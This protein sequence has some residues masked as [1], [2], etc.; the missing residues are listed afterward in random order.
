MRKQKRVLSEEQLCVARLEYETAFL[1]TAKPW[2][3]RLVLILIK[4]FVYVPTV[5][6]DDGERESLRAVVLPTII[7]Y[8]MIPCF[9]FSLL[10]LS[11]LLP[12]NFIL[13]DNLFI[14]SCSSIPFF[15]HS[16]LF[17]FSQSLLVPFFPLHS[18]FFFYLFYF[19]VFMSSL[20][21]YHCSLPSF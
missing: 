13:F 8:H 20:L 5:L 9:S 14:N 17:I 21:F 11:R 19:I 16:P 3:H 4:Q 2:R 18:S 12:F 15:F 10:L 1:L 7:S 6:P